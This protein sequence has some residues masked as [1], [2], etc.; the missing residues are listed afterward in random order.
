MASQTDPSSKVRVGDVVDVLDAM[1]GGRLSAL[2]GPENPWH[3]T[4]D[5]GIPGKAVTESPGLVLGDRSTPVRKLAVAMTM[6]E[7][8]IELA[9]A[10]GVDLIV[11]HHPV[12]DA[13]SS[14]G[15]AMIDYLPR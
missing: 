7:H 3:V 10:I 11:A 8:D 2:P 1:T 9:R 15:V 5:S 12:A 13:A 6:S 4:K 14:G